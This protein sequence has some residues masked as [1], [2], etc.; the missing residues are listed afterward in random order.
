MVK[1]FDYRMFWPESSY[2]WMQEDFEPGL[3]SVVITSYQ[4]EKYIRATLDS[5]LDQ[6]YRPIELV[7]I[8]DGSSDDT[9][10]R[11]RQW[12]EKLPDDEGFKFIAHRQE[13]MGAPNARNRALHLCSGE[14]IQEIGSD[15]LIHPRKIEL[16]VNLLGKESDVQSVWSPLV[17]FT[18]DEESELGEAHKVEQLLSA[19]SR[20]V[21]G[22]EVF[23]PQYLPSAAMHRRQVFYR[24]G[25]WF[26]KLKRWQD[27]EYQSRMFGHVRSWF[28]VPGT[29]YYF[30]QHDGPRINNQY[31]KQSGILPGLDSVSRVESN[32]RTMG[33]LD[34]RVWLEVS[35]FYLT[36]A[37]LALRFDQR[38]A[39]R[40]SLD[41][42]V[43]CRRA[44]LFRFRT[45][46][47]RLAYLVLGSAITTK[48]V[49]RYLPKAGR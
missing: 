28:E 26:E 20:H 19:A 6:T 34:G 13:N 24:A 4:R 12:Q 40:Q 21:R 3:V 25:P 41:G 5:V 9:W 11:V 23:V 36:I 10:T 45:W 42:A 30:R 31:G 32:L 2:E 7:L 16:A 29:P 43:R 22:E 44:P 14:Y 27:L 35:Q 8:D 37:L 1:S 17:H 38:D 46:V 48:F 39:F 47:L 18:D 15:D 33:I 49:S